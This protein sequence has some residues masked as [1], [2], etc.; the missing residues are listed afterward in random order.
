MEVIVKT[1]CLPPE[2]HPSTSAG[3]ECGNESGEILYKR[4][5]VQPD[6]TVST[7]ETGCAIITNR[8]K[9]ISMKYSW[10]GKYAVHLSIQI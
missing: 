8:D 6:Q 9:P 3:K 10:D 1:W 7:T 4:Q 5:Y 2:V